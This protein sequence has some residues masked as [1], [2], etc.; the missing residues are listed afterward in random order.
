MGRGPCAFKAS[1]VARAVKAVA[2]AGQPV[3]GV[4][5]EKDGGFVVMIGE[6]SSEEI[7]SDVNPWDEV[8]N[9]THQKRPT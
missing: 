9:V 3:R 2:A 8:L 6:P 7:S 5:F 1:D 4:R